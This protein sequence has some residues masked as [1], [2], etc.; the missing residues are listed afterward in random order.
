MPP[1]PVPTEPLPPPEDRAAVVDIAERYS[2]PISTLYGLLNSG[3]LPAW[4]L[5]KRKRCSS[6]AA[7]RRFFGDTA[8]PADVA[9][10][11]GSGENRG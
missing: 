6:W 2:L 10:P 11:A 5:G 4:R 9:R 3:D 8:K 1:R 7:V